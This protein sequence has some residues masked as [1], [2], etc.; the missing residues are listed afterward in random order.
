L[1]LVFLLFGGD[2]APTRITQA[3]VCLL[4]AFFFAMRTPRQNRKRYWI[5]LS[6]DRRYKLSASEWTELLASGWAREALDQEKTARP[7]PGVLAWIY[8]GNLHLLAL[9]RIRASCLSWSFAWL[10]KV[11]VVAAASVGED[12]EERRHRVMVEADREAQN[13]A[14]LWRTFRDRRTKGANSFSWIA[15]ETKAEILRAFGVEIK[16]PPDDGGLGVGE[17]FAPGY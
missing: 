15:A 3:Y 14:L 17:A 6:R 10:Y 2:E 9:S 11:G 5:E 13:E 4:S 1:I 7:S 16:S 12:W 8:K